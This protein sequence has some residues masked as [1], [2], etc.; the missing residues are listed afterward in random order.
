M[1][2]LYHLKHL[3]LL[4]CRVLKPVCLYDQDAFTSCCRL[5]SSNLQA[6]A[7]FCHVEADITVVLSGSSY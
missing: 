5:T 4:R 2:V 7:G 1:Q 3:H 6:S